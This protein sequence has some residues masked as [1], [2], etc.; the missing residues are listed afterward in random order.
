MATLDILDKLGLTVEYNSE[1]RR[2]TSCLSTLIQC[3]TAC[4]SWVPPHYLVVWPPG[5][6]VS[7]RTVLV[8]H[9]SMSG[10]EI[11]IP[12]KVLQEHCHPNE[13]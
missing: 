6:S 8:S 2:Y 13:D 5:A 1:S 11:V 10:T 9:Y 12:A 4:P 3:V 7:Y